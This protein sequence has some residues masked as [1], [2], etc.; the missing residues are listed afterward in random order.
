MTRARP[1]GP[2]QAFARLHPPDRLA[3]VIFQGYPNLDPNTLVSLAPKF[4]R[5]LKDIERWVNT[6]AG[7]TADPQQTQAALQ[8]MCRARR[9]DLY[10]QDPKL[11]E[12]YVQ[13]L[14]SKPQPPST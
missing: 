12:G 1:T 7:R 5:L 6:P 10:I 3:G 11:L 8:R 14:R 13:V 9:S 2:P 4:K